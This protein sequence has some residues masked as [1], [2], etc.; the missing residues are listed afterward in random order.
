MICQKL[1]QN[2]AGMMLTVLTIGCTASTGTPVVLVTSSQPATQ[3]P[4]ATLNPTPTP[5]NISSFE[6]CFALGYEIQNTYPRQCISNSG[7]SFTEALGEGIIFSKTYSSDGRFI[8]F[9]RDG[10]YL[11]AGSST[12]CWILKLSATG[13]KV[14][15]SSFHQELS[16]EF[17]LLQMDFW[18][19][20]ARQTPSGDY[21]AMGT[22][23]DANFGQFRKPFIITLDDQGHMMSGQLITEKPGKTP[24]LD[25]D[26]NLIW[27]T[28]LG[29]QREVIETSDGGYIIVGKSPQSPEGSTHMIKTDANGTYMWDRNLCLDKNIQQVWEE[30]IVCSYS[31]VMN[32]IQAQDGSFVIT[33]TTWL[34]KTDASGKVEWIRSYQQKYVNGQ[35]LIQMPDNGFLIAGDIYVDQKKQTDG[36]LIKTDTA[37]NVQWSKTYG[38]DKDDRFRAME[39]GPNGEI[40]IMGWTESFGTG[41]YMWLL[42]MD[43]EHLK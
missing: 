41:T 27:L 18:C 36:M 28:S 43:S 6:E 25:R 15:E 9:T 2:L 29:I 37:G 5:V 3:I 40:I 16:E 30:Q 21:V 34:L 26:G 38:G 8:T 24:Y 31:I 1:L 13:E 22:A 14:W 20:L 33:G 10:G 39:Q 35:A 12:G 42:G 19:W 7:E 23:Y 11:V 32:G 17:Q 4:T